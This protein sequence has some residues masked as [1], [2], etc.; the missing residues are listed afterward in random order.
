MTDIS[1]SYPSTKIGYGRIK[2]NSVLNFGAS[3]TN[4]INFFVIG[5]A[6]S[7]EANYAHFTAAGTTTYTFTTRAGTQSAIRV[8]L[9]YTDYP[10]T[11]ITTG[12]AMVNRLSVQI[13]GG[14][15]TFAPYLVSGTVVDNTQVIDIA[16]PVASTTYTVTVTATSIS[17]PQPYALIVSGAT[18]YL[19]DGPSQDLAYSIPEDNFTA[20]GGALKYILAL[21]ILTLLLA[22]LVYF[23]RRISN[24]KTSMLLDPDSFEAT[25]NYYED[26]VQDGRM[27]G[28]KSIF[29]KIRDIRSGKNKRPTRDMEMEGY[30][31]D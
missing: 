7:S 22:A 28:K 29:A 3:T 13:S 5:G 6:N 16:N 26:G 27:G 17:H 11:A 19:P 8:T 20:S 10:G 4:P 21:G 12:N 2:M 18:T 14:G 24:K 23:I 31:E 15:S 1:A 25:D 30:Y 9:S